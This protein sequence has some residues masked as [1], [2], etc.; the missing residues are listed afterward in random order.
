MG[1]S[2]IL[3]NHH[4]ESLLK[5]LVSQ[6]LD[7]YA[8]NLQSLAIYGSYVNGTA[9]LNSDLDLFIVLKKT[10]SRRQELDYFYESIETPLEKDIFELYKKH[11]INLCLSPFIVSKF[12]AEYFNPLYLDMCENREIIYDKDDFL[13][14]ILEKVKHIKTQYNFKKSIVGDTFKWDMSGYVMLNKR[15]LDEQVI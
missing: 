6:I 11:K 8:D 7:A 9:R 3:F 10:L 2:L 15:V 1:N 4:Q 13:L 12:Q 5:K 14:M